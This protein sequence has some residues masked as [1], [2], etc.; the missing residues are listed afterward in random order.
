[1]EAIPSPLDRMNRAIHEGRDQLQHLGLGTEEAAKAEV[2]VRYVE[3]NP[4]S[5]FASEIADRFQVEIDEPRRK[6]EDQGLGD[7][8]DYALKKIRKELGEDAYAQLVAGTSEAI[9]D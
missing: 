9:E 8:A 6:Q 3:Q 4:T 2:L 7:Y 5:K 1:M